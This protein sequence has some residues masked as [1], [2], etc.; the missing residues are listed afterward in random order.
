MQNLGRNNQSFKHKNEATK[1]IMSPYEPVDKKILNQE[2]IKSRYPIFSYILE[3]QNFI[4]TLFQSASSLTDI[5]TTELTESDIKMLPLTV[6]AKLFSKGIILILLYFLS[7]SVLFYFFPFLEKNYVQLKD[8]KPFIFVFFSMVFW[9]SFCF[10]GYVISSMK[11]FVIINENVK[12]TQAYYSV[13]NKT[14]FC[15]MFIYVFSTII[16]FFLFLYRNEITTI[17]FNILKQEKDLHFINLL[18]AFKTYFYVSL[19]AT[20]GFVLYI[21]TYLIF[22]KKF[23]KQ[24]FINNANLYQHMDLNKSLDMSLKTI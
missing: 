15:V 16:F 24:Q 7:A 8:F 18:A 23:K 13:V 9:G 6:G 12:K 22:Q 14:W 11:Q 5:K 2:R 1:I 19:H 4:Q 20:S 21:L 10:Y 17:I 3:L